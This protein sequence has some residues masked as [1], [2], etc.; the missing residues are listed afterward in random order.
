MSAPPVRRLVLLAVALALLAGAVPGLLACS[1][2]DKSRIEGELLALAKNAPVA[3]LGLE[4]RTL[5]VEL[6]GERHQVEAVFY[7]APR[8][9]DRPPGPRPTVVL[10][11]GTPSSLFSWT[12]VVFGGEGFEGLAATCDVVALDVIGH[13]VTPTRAPPYS[14]QRC[15]DYVA[16]VLRGL[17]LEDVCLVG[18][19]YGGEFVWRAALDHPEL[20]SRVV[21]IDSA[22]YPRRD[23]EWLPEEVKMREWWIAR[24]GY[25]LNSR[26]RILEALQPHFAEPVSA[27]RRDEIY[28]CCANADSWRA[29][30]DLARDENGTR[31]DELKTLRQ[32][33][34]LL[35]GA[36]DIAYKP[37]RFAVL[38]ERDLPDAR[39]VLIEGSGHYPQEEQ[40]AAVVDA[41]VSFVAVEGG[42]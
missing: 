25:V 27:D 10:V 31:S 3:A 34:L 9:V 26:E 2:M 22:G 7:R 36:R 6:E 38:F 17:G 4:R 12:E 16:G 41:I 33:T 42:R 37:E 1:S 35:W 18:Q 5:E 8:P 13:G 23:D 32:P 11:H 39:L 15:A 24:W 20:I 28:L 40:P 30:V 19:S 21:L 14:F 29:M